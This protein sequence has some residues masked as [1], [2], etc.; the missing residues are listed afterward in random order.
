VAVVDNDPTSDATQLENRRSKGK[1]KVLTA[2][3]I[4]QIARKE[5]RHWV[6]GSI[7]FLIVS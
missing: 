1:I 3:E 4:E 7:L 5:E 6:Q 2:D